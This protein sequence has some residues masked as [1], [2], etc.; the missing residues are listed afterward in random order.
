MPCV[1]T[2]VFESTS[3]A[4][5]FYSVSNWQFVGLLVGSIAFNYFTGWLL[6]TKQL[7]SATR[8]AVLT[9]GVA[10]DLE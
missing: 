9:A 6:I 10:G 5:A 1:N 3:I 4:M 2:F 8:F 7:R